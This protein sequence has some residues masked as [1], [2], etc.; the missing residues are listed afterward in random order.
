[1]SKL[2]TSLKV[3][4]VEC[5]QDHECV[6]KSIIRGLASLL[7]AK[8]RQLSKKRECEVKDGQKD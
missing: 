7:D 1:M 8:T 6:I 2:K 3:I 5:P 4:Y